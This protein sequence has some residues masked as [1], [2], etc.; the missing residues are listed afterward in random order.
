M[1]AE[2]KRQFLL[3]WAAMAVGVAGV[4]VA[5]EAQAN[6]APVGPPVSGGTAQP[7]YGARPVP[8]PPVTPPPVRPLYG[9]IL[10]PSG[11]KPPFWGHSGGGTGSR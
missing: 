10:P 4:S 1:E 3:R 7:L 9:P 11:G 8:V 6:T 2:T 5:N